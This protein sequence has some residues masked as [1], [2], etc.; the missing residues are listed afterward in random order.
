MTVPESGTTAARPGTLTLDGLR[1]AV[2]VVL[3]FAGI[4]WLVSAH[5]WF[6]GPKVLSLI[7]I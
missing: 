5:N 7:H 4:Y 6:K 3:G 2:G 1:G